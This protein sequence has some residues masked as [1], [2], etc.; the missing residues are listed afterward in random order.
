MLRMLYWDPS[1]CSASVSTFTKRSCSAFAWEDCSNTGAKPTQGPHHGAQKSTTTGLSP[2]IRALKFALVPATGLPE[3]KGCLQAPQLG[4]SCTLSS[5]RR[6]FFWQWGQRLVIVG[7][8]LDSGE[9]VELVLI[10][11]PALQLQGR[12]TYLFVRAVVSCLAYNFYFEATVRFYFKLITVG[13]G[14]PA[15]GAR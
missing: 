4:S 8:S 9:N 10:W 15:L 3:N 11:C 5:G 1:I 14:V 6:L 12:V 2:W 13:K 7:I